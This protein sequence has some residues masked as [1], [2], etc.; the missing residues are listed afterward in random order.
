[1]FLSKS[2]LFLVSLAII[3]VAIWLGP[4]HSI[5]YLIDGA[6]F[7]CNSL[8]GVETFNTKQPNYVDGNWQPIHRELDRVTVEGKGN[9]PNALKGGMYIRNG[10]NPKCWPPGGYV[11]NHAFNG[12][13]MIH[14]CM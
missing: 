8:D 13:A 9:L 6:L 5:I 1:M 7:I 14:R 4:T 11:R 10:A 12:E 2:N 3:G